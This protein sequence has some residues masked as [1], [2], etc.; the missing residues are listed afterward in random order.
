MKPRASS[1][2]CSPCR[3]Q[4][5]PEYR[6]RG[7]RCAQAQAQ[8]RSTLLALAHRAGGGGSRRSRGR[9]R[10]W[11][12][13]RR[14]CGPGVGAGLWISEAPR[15]AEPA[16]RRGAM[17]IGTEISRKIR[18]RPASGGGGKPGLSGRARGCQE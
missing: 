9:E 14:S 4:R 5:S 18:V 10:R 8:A 16:A 12:L 11:R 17:E 15:S 3:Q 1:R 2:R 6:L 13:R 7:P